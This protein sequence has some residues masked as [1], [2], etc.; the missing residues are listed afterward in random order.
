MN[1]MVISKA[2]KIVTVTDDSLLILIWAATRQN[3]SSGSDKG[4]LK[5]LP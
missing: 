2:T 4:R 1:N 5:P 3:L